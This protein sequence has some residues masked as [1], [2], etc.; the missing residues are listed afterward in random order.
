MLERSYNAVLVW[1]YPARGLCSPGY[2]LMIKSHSGSILPWEWRMADRGGVHDRGLGT[3]ID[4]PNRRF[5]YVDRAEA[6]LSNPRRSCLMLN[7]ASVSILQVI[8]QNI[9]GTRALIPQGDNCFFCTSTFVLDILDRDLLVSCIGLSHVN[10]EANEE[11]SGTPGSGWVTEW[12]QNLGICARMCN[13]TDKCFFPP[14]KDKRS[15]PFP[16]TCM[17]KRRNRQRSRWR[18]GGRGVCSNF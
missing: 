15:Q 4:A 17:Q 18:K 3:T 6:G 5:R 8:V 7:A 16:L 2:A 1:Y 14:E 12:D 9:A 13:A 11:T 10:P